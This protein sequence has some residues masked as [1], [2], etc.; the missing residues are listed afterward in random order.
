M[1]TITATIEHFPFL[2][3]SCVAS[4]TV[5]TKSVLTFSV[6]TFTCFVNRTVRIKFS[7]LTFSCFYLLRS[8]Q[9]KV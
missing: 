4:Q 5:R 2:T 7:V 8:K 3:F 6:Q 1:V 9:V